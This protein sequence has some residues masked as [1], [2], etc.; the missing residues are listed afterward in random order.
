[1]QSSLRIEV[2]AGKYYGQA[3]TS[4]LYIYLAYQILEATP[5]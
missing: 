1:M 4:Y 3:A 5:L 2:L